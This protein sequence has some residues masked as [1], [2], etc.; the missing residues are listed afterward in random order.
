MFFLLRL[1]TEASGDREP[2]SITGA[3]DVGHLSIVYSTLEYKTN[4]P[5]VKDVRGNNRADWI[6]QSRG[7]YGSTVEDSAARWGRLLPLRLGHHFGVM[8]CTIRD[9]LPTVCRAALLLKPCPSSQSE[10]TH[11]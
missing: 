10:A 6:A 9:T 8:A 3:Y 7:L 11:L 1:V 2:A 5:C 4:L